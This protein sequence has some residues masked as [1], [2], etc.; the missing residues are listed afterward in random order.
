MPFF[1][2]MFS[3]IGELLPTWLCGLCWDSWVTQPFRCTPLWPAS[4][5]PVVDKTRGSKSVEVQR[6]WEVYD[7]RLQFMSRRD[8]SLLDES[9]GLDDVS[10]AW[11][12]WSRAAEAALADAYQFSG[13][14]LPSTGLILGRGAALFRMVQLGGQWV[15]RARANAADALDAA[16]VFLYRDFSIALLLDM[17]RRFKA[18]MDILDAMIRYGVSLSRSV[19]LTAQWD[20]ILALDPM[21]R[22]TEDDLS[23]GRGLDIGAFF[24]VVAGVHRRLC[25]F[26]HQV[27]VNRRDE[28]VGGWRNWI[29]EDPL[30]H[31]NRWLRPDLVPPAPFLQC[32]PCLT[33]DGSGV[34]SDPNQID[35]EFRKAWL[36]Y[37]CR[38]GQR[39]TSLDE[40]GFEVDG[41]LP[42]LPEI[43]LPR[44]T[45]QMHADVVL[46]YGVSAGSLDGCRWRELKVLPVSWFDELARI[47]TKVEDL[48]VW[49]DGLLD[50]YITMIPKTDGDSTP[51]GQRPLSVLPVVYRI[52][53]SVRMVQLQDW[54]RSWVPDSVY[55]AGGGR[56]SVEAWYTAAL[57]S[58]IHL[59]VADVVKSFD[60]VDRGILD[61][62]L[63][64]LGLPGWFRHAY[65]EY[66]AHV[67]LRFKLASGLGRS[68]TRDGGIPQGCPLSMM[69]IVALYLPWCRY[70][71]AQVGVRPQL[72][73]DNLKCLSRDP[74]LLLHAA[75]FTTGYVRLVG[76]EPAPS[77][78]V[79]LSTSRE[80]RKDMK[81]WVLS[82]EGDQWSVR[83]DVRD[84]GG[85]YLSWVVF[86]SC[87]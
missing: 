21:Y 51:L 2:A 3:R 85:H 7:E 72:Y 77:K 48:G 26:V 63:S 65:F 24:D 29:R 1:L 54:F 64:S 76:Q 36:P 82:C 57:D 45:G 11:T 22:V 14:L 40:F 49:P 69:F 52:G 44:L 38:S 62:V 87:C 60:T 17:R 37:F 81:D 79:H 39:E 50:A 80:I 30:V 56:R 9:L 31:P 67:R 66:H 41:W 74:D 59:F 12:V 33:P 25:E 58:D 5:L 19:E 18:V 28:A 83:F 46:H 53:V 43:H 8:A 27:V 68:W 55:S 75:R 23:V 70:L 61:R 73:A 34:L 47:L 6:V 16:D 4:W 78:C 20:Q 35:A 32:E 84:L 10:M 71:S 86:D 42:I 15:R 13:G